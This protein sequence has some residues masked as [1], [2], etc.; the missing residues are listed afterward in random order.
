MSKFLL[1]LAPLTLLALAGCNQAGDTTDMEATDDVAAEAAPMEL[2]P[3]IVDSGTYRCADGSV[4]YVDFYQGGKRAGVRTEQNGISVILN[5]P[6][7]EADAMTA[8]PETGATPEGDAMADDGAVADGGAMTLVADGG[9]ELTGT[10]QSID[11]KLPE[12][13]SQTCKSG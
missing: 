3:A 5:A 13:D 2:P 1:P 8:A 9:Y 10:G 7:A 12:K 6:N 11:V 4:I